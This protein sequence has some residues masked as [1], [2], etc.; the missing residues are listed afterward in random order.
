MGETYGTYVGNKCF[1]IRDYDGDTDHDTDDDTNDDTERDTVDGGRGS[2]RLH[3]G[4][5]PPPHGHHEA[6]KTS[7]FTVCPSFFPSCF[8]FLFALRSKET[9]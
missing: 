2:R 6:T 9:S 4:G 3:R 1:H 8:K 5:V 7:F